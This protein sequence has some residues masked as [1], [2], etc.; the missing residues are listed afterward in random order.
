VWRVDA[1]LE[2]AQ[3]ARLRRLR[4]GRHAA[5]AE[6]ALAELETAARSSRNLMPLILAAVEAY[7]TVGEISDALGRVFGAYRESVGV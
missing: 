2:R 3:I 6:R 1:A 5:A 4:A 7:C